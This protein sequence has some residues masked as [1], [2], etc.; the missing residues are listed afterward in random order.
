MDIFEPWFYILFGVIVF[1]KLVLWFFDRKKFAMQRTGQEEKRGLRAVPRS[2]FLGE[3]EKSF[4]STIMPAG[5]I[6]VK[7]PEKPKLHRGKW[8]YTQPSL[9]SAR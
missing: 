8:S 1:I 6:K 4:H 7:R 2:W 3:Y 9:A 5:R